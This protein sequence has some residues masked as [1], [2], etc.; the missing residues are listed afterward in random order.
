M[1]GERRDS[2]CALKSITEVIG[3]LERYFRSIEK[4]D[5][6]AAEAQ[7]EEGAPRRERKAKAG[8]KKPVVEKE[9]QEA[10]NAAVASKFAKGDE[11]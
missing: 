3:I 10:I 4:A 9:D 1:S 2:L 5:S 8:A 7:D 11:E 6:A